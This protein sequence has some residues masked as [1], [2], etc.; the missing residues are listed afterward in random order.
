MEQAQL[1]LRFGVTLFR[2][3]AVMGCSVRQVDEHPFP[4]GVA[5][6][7]PIERF[8]TCRRCRGRSARYARK[9]AHGS[10]IASRTPRITPFTR[11]MK[12]ER[13]PTLMSTPN[14][15]PGTSRKLSGT[16]WSLTSIN[17]IR[18]L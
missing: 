6:P 9:S 7:E 11:Y 3:P 17:V 15:M 16:A 12:A 18:A 4:T 5:R 2:R 8:G 13:D 10:R 14:V 1:K